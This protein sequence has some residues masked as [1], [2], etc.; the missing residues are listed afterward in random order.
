MNKP[1]LALLLILITGLCGLGLL[2]P[3][4][5]ALF[6]GTISADAGSEQDRPRPANWEQRLRAYHK[7]NAR[8]QLNES[9]SPEDKRAALERLRNE[10]FSGEEIRWLE[11]FPTTETAPQTPPASPH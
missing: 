7:A 6:A 10:H 5:Q 4:S 3:P 8:L 9:L 2:L 1:L 11:R